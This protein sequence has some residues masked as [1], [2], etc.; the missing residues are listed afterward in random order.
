MPISFSPQRWMSDCL[1]HIGSMQL[2][3]I[4][5]PATHDS[6]MSKLTWCTQLGTENNSLTQTHDIAGQLQ[7]GIRQFDIRPA[8]EPDNTFWSYHV[9]E[10]DLLGWQGGRGQ[11]LAEIIE[12]VNAF[13]VRNPE[14]IILDISHAIPAVIAACWNPVRTP[15]SRLRL[16]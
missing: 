10:S 14:I 6:G 5:I 1:H 16:G 4:C 7:L 15:P 9:S 8:L 11:S 12:Q 3:D 2:R 13:T